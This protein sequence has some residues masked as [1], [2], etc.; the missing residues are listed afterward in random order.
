MARVPYKDAADLPADYQQ[1]MKRPISL[2]RGL[3]NSPGALKVHHEFGEWIRWESKL[4]PKLREHI[5]LMV[6]LMH[7]SKYEVSHHIQIAMDNFGVTE[8]EIWDLIAYLDSRPTSFSPA[9][10]AALELARELILTGQYSDEKWQAAA[11]HF[12]SEELADITVIAAFYVY[13]VLVL[14]GL[15][16]DVEPDYF[17]YLEKFNLQW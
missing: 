14:S 12:D 17:Q 4:D 5:I 1:Y 8:A 9:S 3:A 10:L 11:G 6:G 7:K 13:V 16:I 15:E 2:F